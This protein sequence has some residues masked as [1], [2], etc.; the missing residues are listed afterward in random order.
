[1]ARIETHP[2]PQVGSALRWLRNQAG[3]QQREVGERM[4]QLDGD[5]ITPVWLSQIENGHRQPSW[6]LVHRLLHVYGVADLV[7]L[8]RLLTQRP[9]VTDGL[10][11]EE[12]TEW[13]DMPQTPVARARMGSIGGEALAVSLGELNQ[14]FVTLS[15]SARKELLRTARQLASRR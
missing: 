2:N 13:G 7:E 12:G 9:W 8:E 11:V 14:L 15:P 6:Q 4:Q 3:L 5:G 1:M 10:R